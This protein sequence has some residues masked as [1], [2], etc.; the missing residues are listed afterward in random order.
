MSL[1]NQHPKSH[2]VNKPLARR[3]SLGE[4]F[5]KTRST[6]FCTVEICLNKPI[7]RHSLDFSCHSFQQPLYHSLSVSRARSCICPSQPKPWA[8]VCAC[9]NVMVWVDVG[10]LAIVGMCLSGSL[11][12][13]FPVSV[14]APAC[15][16]SV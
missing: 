12:L 2:T 6:K 16:L 8:S 14:S 10:A 15:L 1:K 5:W 11:S 4:L 9:F 13:P 7:A 3:S